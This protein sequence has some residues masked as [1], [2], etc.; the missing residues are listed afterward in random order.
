MGAPRQ[1]EPR[2]RWPGGNG[3][4]RTDSGSSRSR[5]HRRRPR[6]AGLR[7][8][9]A[10]GDP[11]P[12]CPEPHQTP[13]RAR[14]SRPPTRGTRARSRPRSGPGWNQVAGV[15][16]LT[17]EQP[18]RAVKRGVAGVPVARQQKGRCVT[19]G[20]SGSD[21]ASRKALLQAALGR[22]TSRREPPHTARRSR[23]EAD[24]G[25]AS[26]RP[27][28]SEMSGR[29]ERGCVRVK[30]PPHVDRVV[31]QQTAAH[32]PH[33]EQIGRDGV[34][35]APDSRQRAGSTVRSVV[36]ERV[37]WL[38]ALTPVDNCIADRIHN[39]SD[40]LGVLAFQRSLFARCAHQMNCI[41]GLFSSLSYIYQMQLKNYKKQYLLTVCRALEHFQVSQM[42][43]PGS[44]HPARQIL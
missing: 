43:T 35:D 8:G 27:R 37:M 7:A 39:V 10:S 4:R 2:V 42:S 34:Q 31:R 40:K 5:R 16:H 15:E 6:G 23:I 18:R 22:G 33:S 30:P 3:P 38:R 21:L 14:G 20:G 9:A 25:S 24:V 41:Q 19:R 26:S 1:V 36:Q 12:A 11:R 28:W 13:G 29:A 17:A 44:V 32:P